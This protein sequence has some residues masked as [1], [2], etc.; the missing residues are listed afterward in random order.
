MIKI[1]EFLRVRI[2]LKMAPKSERETDTNPFFSYILWG[3]IELQLN[4]KGL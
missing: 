3:L 2:K 4:N 1:D